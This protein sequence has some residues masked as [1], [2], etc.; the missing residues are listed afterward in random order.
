ML[1]TYPPRVTYHQVYQ[2]TKIEV[3]VYTKIEVSVSQ[4][5]KPVD[6]KMDATTYLKVELEAQLQSPHIFLFGPHPNDPDSIVHCS[7]S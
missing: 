3:S 7:G 1:K 5:F 2:Y 6:C 4:S